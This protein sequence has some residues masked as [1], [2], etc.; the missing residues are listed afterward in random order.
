[1]FLLL[2]FLFISD[3][4][5]KQDLLKTIYYEDDDIKSAQ[6]YKYIY[7]YIYIYICIII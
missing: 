4:S 5:N 2:F 7:I 1:M 3:I 6:K